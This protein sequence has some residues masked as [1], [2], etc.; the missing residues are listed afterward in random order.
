MI[1]NSRNFGPFNS[2][3]NGIIAASGDGV[4][5]FVPAD[6]QDP[7]ELI[8][9]FV[10]KWEEGF[11]VVYGVR[12][13]REEGL[14]MRGVRRAYYRLVAEMA[15]IELRPGVGEFQF[16]D[17]KVIQALRQF[18]DFYPYV[19]GMVAYCGFK[20]TGIEYTWRARKRGFSKNSLLRLVDQGL[21]GMI[22]FTKVPLRICMAFG[23]LIALASITFAVFSLIINL[24]YYRQ[25]TS[26]GIPTLI[27]AVFFFSG[28]QLFFFG[29][30][31]EYIASIHMQVRKRP[32]VIESERLNFPT[33][34]ASHDDGH[35]PPSVPAIF[36]QVS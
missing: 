16:V 26:P 5:L 21:N 19:R 4:A 29:V 32:H 31:G 8:P 12:K 20:S 25:L 35:A 3:F 11:D 28:L 30:I 13:V 14:M 22:S 24:T 17:R 27:V 23:L 33:S 7:P 1:L 2:L 18:D 36:N 15:Y 9:Q 6:L 10:Q 34:G